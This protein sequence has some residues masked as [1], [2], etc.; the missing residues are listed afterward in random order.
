MVTVVRLGV[1][2]TS[3]VLVVSGPW[4]ILVDIET[5]VTGGRISVSRTVF[6]VGA[7]VCIIVST[8]VEA[9]TGELPVEA[10]ADP[11]STATTE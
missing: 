1:I 7:C 3:T 6:V 5:S 11:P 4:I 2:V 9:A 8:I 10:A